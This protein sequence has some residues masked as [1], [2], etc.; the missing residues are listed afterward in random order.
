MGTGRVKLRLLTMPFAIPGNAKTQERSC[1]IAVLTMPIH[2][3]L[4]KVKHFEY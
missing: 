3:R 2:H 4:L 1:G